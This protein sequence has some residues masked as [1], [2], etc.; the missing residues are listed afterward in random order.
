MDKQVM[1]WYYAH[2]LKK[3]AEENGVIFQIRLVDVEGV[4]EARIDIE[5]ALEKPDP[6]VATAN[7]MNAYEEMLKKQHAFAEAASDI[8][9]DAGT[10]VVRFRY[11]QKVT[12]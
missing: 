4:Q 7:E 12:A 8:I 10:A 6:K 5:R 3:V 2:K 9:N 1:A 11:P